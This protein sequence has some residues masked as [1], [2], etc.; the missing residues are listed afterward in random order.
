MHYAP[1]DP[2]LP[3]QGWKIHVSSCLADAE[4]ALGAVWDYCVPRGLA[5][6][7]LRSESVAIMMNS[8]AA[9][10]GSSGKLVTIYPQDEDQLELVLK[11]LDE[12]LDGIQ[13]P[14]GLEL[15]LAV[16]S[17]WDGGQ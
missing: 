9:F 2:G 14:N 4:R 7:F 5:F 1:H 10:R 15:G 16:G 11:E 12:L 3:L 17:S 13:G 8:K 6:K